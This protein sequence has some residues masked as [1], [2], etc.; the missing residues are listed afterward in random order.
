MTSIGT[1]ADMW[2]AIRG[3]VGSQVLVR[4]TFH[5]HQT[6]FGPIRVSIFGRRI[7]RAGEPVREHCQ[8][9]TAR[10]RQHFRESSR[11]Q[12]VEAPFN[13]GGPSLLRLKQLGMLPHLTLLEAIVAY[14]PAVRGSLRSSVFEHHDES[15]AKRDAGGLS[16]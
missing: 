13:S 14:P 7:L 1:G 11:K 8:E 3:S 12:R 9:T 10:I 5:I 6:F 15:C 2:A 4:A 16:R